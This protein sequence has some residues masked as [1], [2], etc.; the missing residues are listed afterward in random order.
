MC[1]SAH[2]DESN[3][4]GALVSSQ[5][6]SRAGR[7]LPPLSMIARSRGAVRRRLFTS[8]RCSWAIERSRALHWSHR[9]LGLYPSSDM[10]LD[11][12]QHR[13]LAEIG[14]TAFAMEAV[15]RWCIAAAAPDHPRDERA[16]PS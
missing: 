1:A 7:S 4:R 10:L 5:V 13:E 12:L 3:P 9:N 2:G 16:A 8:P 15:E 6:K 11:W 14:M